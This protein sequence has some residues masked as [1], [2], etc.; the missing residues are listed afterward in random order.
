MG[1]KVGGAINASTWNSS[2]HGYQEVMGERYQLCARSLDDAAHDAAHATAAVHKPARPQH[3]FQKWLA[4][5]ACVNGADGVAGIAFI[6]GNSEKCARDAGYEWAAL[7]GC[8]EGPKGLQLFHESVYYTY[9]HHVIYD[10]PPP[11]GE[12]GGIPVIHINGKK[13][14][15]LDAYKNLTSRICSAAP[16]GTP[17]GCDESVLASRRRQA[18][19]RGKR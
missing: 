5:E 8:A 9:N 3:H 12:G 14:F 2:F 7:K 11:L 17:C 19:R 10:F 4:F 13:F 15:G 16:A 1:G 6:P 18:A